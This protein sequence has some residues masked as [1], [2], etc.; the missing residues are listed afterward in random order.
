MKGVISYRSDVE[1]RGRIHFGL[2]RMSEAR[3]T[4]CCRAWEVICDAT[5]FLDVGK[6]KQCG[7]S[8][9]ASRTTII[10]LPFAL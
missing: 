10:Y 1:R 9:T 4:D 2:G 7:T 8:A 3:L 5:L 6:N